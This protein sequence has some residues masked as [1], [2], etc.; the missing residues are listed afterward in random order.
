MKKTYTIAVEAT[1]DIIG[2][3]WKPVI[4][5]HLRQGTLRTSELRRRIPKITQKMLTQQLR[6]LESDNIVSRKVYNQ[7][8]P[9]VE[10]ALT[11]QGQSLGKLMSCM[12]EWGK[13]AINERIAAGEEIELLDEKF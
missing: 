3:K 7:I 9:K 2:G 10:Y 4:I 5:C 11:E 6:E 1:L 8:P 12:S 13:K